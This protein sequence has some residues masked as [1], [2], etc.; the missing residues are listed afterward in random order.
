MN[1]LKLNAFHISILNGNL[2]VARLFLHR[3]NIQIYTHNLT[4]ADR[5]A[6][7][8]SKAAQDGRTPLQL[9]LASESPDMVELLVKEATVH[10]V[11][12]C[13]LMIHNKGAEASKAPWLGIKAIL[14]TKV[15]S[16]TALGGSL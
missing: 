9:A 14:A 1:K 7:H 3:H 5:D 15:G 12:A 10:D 11:E 6:F 16:T 2:S 13:W 4:Q 8:P